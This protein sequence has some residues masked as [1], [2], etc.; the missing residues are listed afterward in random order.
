MKPVRRID[1]RTILSKNMNTIRLI[2]GLVTCVFIFATAQTSS[3]AVFTV[4]N[5]N[6]GGA[7][8]LRQAVLDANVNNEDDTINFDAGVFS[9]AR[10]ILLTSGELVVTAD[11]A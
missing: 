8:S 4:T 6:D 11:D 3:A 5:T 1:R 9:T 10:Q 2:A 7:G